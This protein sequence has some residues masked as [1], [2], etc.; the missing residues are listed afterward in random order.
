MSEIV[1]G[2]IQRVTFHSGDTGYGVFRLKTETQSRLVTMV[3]VLQRPTEGLMIRASGSWANHPKFGKQFKAEVIEELLPKTAT[4]IKA[5]LGSGLIKGIGPKTAEKIVNTFGEQTLSILDQ[6]ADRLGEIRGFS[7]KKVDLVKAGWKKHQSIR[8]VM[9]FLQSH[10]I[11]TAYAFRIF[12]TYGTN[13]VQVIQ[14]NPYKLADDVRGIGFKLADRI[15]AQCGIEKSDP[16]RIQSGLRYALQDAST[17]GH[18]LMIND[19]LVIQATKLLE[20]D[21]VPIKEALRVL[22]TSGDF[23]P[24]VYECHDAVALKKYYDIAREVYLCLQIRKK[25]LRHSEAAQEK[26]SK[27]LLTSQKHLS[28][29]QRD[30][31]EGMAQKS[32]SILTGGPGCGKT[33]TLK[34]FVHYY[35]SI[36]KRVLCCAPTGKAACRMEEVIGE[37]AKT[38]H[39]LLEY[40]P[41]KNVFVRNKSYPLSGDV[42]IVDESSMIDIELALALLM[43]VPDKMQI[44]W[45]GDKDQLPSVGP[46]RFFANIIQMNLCPVYRLTHIFRQGERSHI[47]ENA[48]RVNKGEFPKLYDREEGGRDFFF[49]ER[50]RTEDIQ[51]TLLQSVCERIPK[52]FGLQATDIKVLAPMHRGDIGTIKLNQCLQHNLN[53]NSSRGSAVSVTGVGGTRFYEG[54]II[55]QKVNNYNINVMNGE[56]GKIES[57]NS[58]DQEVTVQFEDKKVIYE[59]SDFQDVD[60]GYSLSIHKSQGSEFPAVV[61]PIHE[62]QFIMLHRTL[63]YTG[64]TR[65]RQLCV[66]IGTKRAIAIAIKRVNQTERKT[67]L[68]LF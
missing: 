49:I 25:E 21:E 37:H 11:S 22:V 64:I 65:A 33:T 5:F 67:L 32:Q 23:C 1:E 4:G 46:G 24:V 29:E 45:V 59:I 19:D 50:A 16:K 48:H 3:G 39:R 17:L 47:V 12:K 20:V 60:L 55:L 68:P 41:K 56:T 9:M 52:T 43:A 8:E 57:I 36:G 2:T 63:L 6:S 27:W 14:E 15:A 58:E 53:P 10:G 30:A 44:I 38:I 66:L 26:I 54:D 13:C 61:I 31:V 7:P 35:K 40:D 28:L 18:T 51:A 34:A 42:L 62:S